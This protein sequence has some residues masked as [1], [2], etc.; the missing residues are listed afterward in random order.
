V[1]PA[2]VRDRAPSG[3]AGACDHFAALREQCWGMGPGLYRSPMYAGPRTRA[4]FEYQ[5]TCVALRSIPNLLPGSPVAAVAVEWST[6]YVL[7]GRDGQ[8]E[9]VSVKH[10][11]PGQGDWTFAHLKAENVFRDLHGVWRAMNETGV[12][13]FE[14]NR[15]R[16]GLAERSRASTMSPAVLSRATKRSGR[17]ENPS[18]RRPPAA[19]LLPPL[20]RAGA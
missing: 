17:R 12:F 5:D 2:T 14:S 13:V 1:P 19:R 8:R 20:P 7:L 16:L 9:L 11:E 3:T 10:R 18:G 4:L 6:D 15:S